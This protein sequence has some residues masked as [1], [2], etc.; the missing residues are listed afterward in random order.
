MNT[1]KKWDYYEFTLGSW[2]ASAIINGDYSGLTDDE[3]ARL[4]EFMRDR[5]PTGL[6]G[7]W[8]GFDEET[9]YRGF[10][11]DEITGLAGDCYKARFMFMVD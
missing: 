2:W 4:D 3:S 6:R 5:I 1:A 10:T 11:R 9:D 8:D 7:H